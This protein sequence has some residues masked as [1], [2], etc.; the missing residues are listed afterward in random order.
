[1]PETENTL[2]KKLDRLIGQSIITPNISKRFLDPK[3]RQKTLEKFNF[4]E[5]EIREIMNLEF[6]S[7]EDFGKKAYEAFG[8]SSDMGKERK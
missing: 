6:E 2:I 7:I 4:E 1:M 3:T 8:I 5:N